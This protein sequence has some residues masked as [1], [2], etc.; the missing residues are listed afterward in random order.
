MGVVD[1]FIRG[2]QW[3]DAAQSAELE[4]SVSRVPLTGAAFHCLL[5]LITNVGN[6]LTEIHTR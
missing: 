4:S 5:S 6:A 3:G 2:E 1:L